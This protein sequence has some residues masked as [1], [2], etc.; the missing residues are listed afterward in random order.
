MSGGQAQRLALARALYAQC[1]FLLLD[2]P[3]SALDPETEQ[4]VVATFRE[5]A[6]DRGLLIVSHRPKPLECC[7]EVYEMR[8]GQLVLT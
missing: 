6:A 4:D 2:E 1:R 8:Q 7:D 5:L 3:T